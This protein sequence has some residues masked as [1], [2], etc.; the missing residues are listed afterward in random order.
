MGLN[1]AAGTLDISLWIFLRFDY[2]II[3][4]Q[5]SRTI[6]NQVW[7]PTAKRTRL[8][9]NSFFHPSPPK[10]PRWPLP[11]RYDLPAAGDFPKSSPASGDAVPQT[12]K[13]LLSVRLWIGHLLKK[14]SAA[15]PPTHRAAADVCLLFGNGY[16]L[17][18][19]KDAPSPPSAAGYR[20][21]S[22]TSKSAF[23]LPCFCSP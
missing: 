9:F 23:R 14:S 20:P 4:V 22:Q 2:F 21:Q 8:Q 7:M 19:H 18:R 3:C 6:I 5:N 15:C 17:R 16:L 10:T 12:A 1:A 11:Q 13:L